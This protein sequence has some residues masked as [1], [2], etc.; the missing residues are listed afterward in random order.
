MKKSA[1]HIHRYK[2][3]DLSRDK[4]KPYL[5]YQCIKPNCSHYL[6]IAQSLNKVCECN[7]CFNPMIISQVTLTR[8]GG[9]PMAKPRCDECIKRKHKDELSAIS[10]FLANEDK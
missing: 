3:I 5:V 10:E 7:V 2:K 4:N 9:G 8:S 6:P 1:N